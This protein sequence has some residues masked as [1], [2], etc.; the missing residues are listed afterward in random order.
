MVRALEKDKDK[1]EQQI[2]EAKVSDPKIML[3]LLNCT[4]K[5]AHVT[6]GAG[7]ESH[8]K[9]V[10]YAP[11]KYVLS[12]GAR[13]PGQF[14]VMFGVD[15]DFF[16]AGEGTLDITKFDSSG[17]AGTFEFPAENTDFKTKEKK[18]VMVKGKFDYACATPSAACKH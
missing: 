12:S 11:G 18:K 4:G 7:A 8:Y 10:P 13:K 14:S 2:A 1:A 9:D 17:I 6:I 15:H 3:L 5:R 16:S